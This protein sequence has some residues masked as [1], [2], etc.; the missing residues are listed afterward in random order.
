LVLDCVNKDGRSQLLGERKKVKLPGPRRKR[1]GRE[2]GVRAGGGAEK[3]A[4][5]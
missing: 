1:R 4:D 2:G 5:M 3:T